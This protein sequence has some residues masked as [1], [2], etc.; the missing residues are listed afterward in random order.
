VPGLTGLFSMRQPP[1]P[2]HRSVKV[3]FNEKEMTCFD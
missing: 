3:V 2:G 1:K